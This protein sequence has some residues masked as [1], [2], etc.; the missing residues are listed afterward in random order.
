MTTVKEKRIT[1]KMKENQLYYG[2]RR[3]GITIDIER[4]RLYYDS[5]KATEGEP[6]VIR[7]GKAMAH[8]LENK[9][10]YILPHERIVGNITAKPNAQITYPSC[11]GGGW[12]RRL[13]LTIET[14]SLQTKRG[15]SCM[16]SISIFQSMPFMGR[17][18]RCCLRTYYPTG[19]MTLTGHSPGSTGDGRGY[20]T[21]KRCSNWV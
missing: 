19:V 8:L 13:I 3:P 18:A 4:P 10:L 11:G 9:T 20:L 16:K 5:Y 15:K 14:V 1:E 7:R 12:I 6:M 21:T 17:S 2:V